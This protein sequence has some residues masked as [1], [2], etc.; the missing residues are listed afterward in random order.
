MTEFRSMRDRITDLLRGPEMIRIR[1][2]SRLLH[3]WALWKTY[4]DM[5]AVIRTAKT[6]GGLSSEVAR[7]PI[8]LSLFLQHLR[9]NAHRHID[10][11]TGTFFNEAI[12]GDEDEWRVWQENGYSLERDGGNFPKRLQRWIN[13]YNASKQTYEKT[14]DARNRGYTN[15]DIIPYWKLWEVGVYSEGGFGYPSYSGLFYVDK[16]MQN[17]P[18]YE[19]QAAMYLETYAANALFN[20]NSAIQ[21]PPPFRTTQ[22]ISVARKSGL[23]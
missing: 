19:A 9:D 22:W 14:I 13:Y 4:Q 11:E 18:K 21:Y 3:H 5:I 8:L 20:E 15:A 1:T 6:H 7:R 16:A 23:V 12:I 10:I 2:I 17:Q